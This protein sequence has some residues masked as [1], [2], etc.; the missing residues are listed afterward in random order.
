MAKRTVF[1][2][3]EQTMVFEHPD[4][5]ICT[6]VAHPGQPLNLDPT[7]LRR[8]HGIAAQHVHLIRPLSETSHRPLTDDQKAA[9][10]GELTSDQ[11]DERIRQLEAD[12]EA[13]T[14]PKGRAKTES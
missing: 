1:E 11:K 10:R 5:G 14:A 12:L 3:A 6:V 9:E 2:H 7:H 13:A 4:T 8:E